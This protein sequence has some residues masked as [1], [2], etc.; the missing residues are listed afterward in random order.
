LRTISAKM[1][2]R[3]A[4]T[5]ILVVALAAV[6]I[7]PVRL[8][9]F[10]NPLFAAAD[11]TATG[12]VDES[13]NRALSAFA[14]ARATNAV[15]SVIQETE[16]EA[17]PAGVGVSLALGQ[18]L[19]P[20]NDLV[21]RFSWVMLVALTSLGIQKILIELSPW[22]STQVLAM[23][24]LV[25]WCLG[26]WLQDWQRIDL[27][28]MGKKLLILAALVRFAVPLAAW[29]NQVV[30]GAVLA[31]RY[32][33]AAAGAEE[34]RAELQGAD[35]TRAAIPPEESATTWWQRLRGTL[36]RAEETLDF[37]Q[38]LDW[39][40]QESSQLINNFLTLTVVFLLN[41]ILFPVAFLWIL[42]R[43]FGAMSARLL[44]ARLG[45][46]ATENRIGEQRR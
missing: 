17:S 13:F 29:A 4:R 5:L 35:P 42:F 37:D 24:A 34:S 8:A 44:P 28:G 31:D 9:L 12:Y 19:D 36:A 27:I 32:Q 2:G 46:V 15:I 1:K 40:K 41:T 43:F 14:L 16:I 3:I 18:I 26:V 25:L 22:F 10:D 39:T 33:E 21:E 38:V 7:A 30:Y 45:A 6:M 20:V 23:V 11:R